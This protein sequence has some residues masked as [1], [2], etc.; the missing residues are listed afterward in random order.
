MTD[1]PIQPVSPLPDDPRLAPAEAARLANSAGTATRMLADG[2]AD[3]ETLRTALPTDG[4]AERV[5][6]ET[7]LRE[8]VARVMVAERAPASLHASVLAAMRAEPGSS[9]ESSAESDHSADADPAPA[10]LTLSGATRSRSFWNRAAGWMALAAVLALAGLGIFGGLRTINANDGFSPE[11]R[12]DLIS[13]ATQE[14]E[15]SNPDCEQATAKFSARCRAKSLEM[16]QEVLGEAPAGLFDRIE[17]LRENGYRFVGLGRCGL[18]GQGASVHVLLVTP[19][20]ERASLFVQVYSEE[21]T[22]RSTC[23]YTSE[24]CNKAGGKMMAWR[25]EGYVYY[26]F[27]ASDAAHREVA[28]V[29]A[30][31]SENRAL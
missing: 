7:H 15:S 10:P 25:S 30:V 1:R 22:I 19:D 6:Y 13:Y 11:F 9:A 16:M 3:A 5:A 2:E 27:T 28:R 8:A 17:T 21:A 23:R 12:Q 20:A 14:H 29:F 26:L 24:R 4:V 18:P 31:P